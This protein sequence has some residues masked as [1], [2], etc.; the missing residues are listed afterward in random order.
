MEEAEGLAYDDLRSDS[1]AMVTGVDGSQG[2]ELSLHDVATHS[3][4]HTLRSSAPCMP[5]SPMEHMPLLEAAVAGIDAVKVHV[6][7]EKLNNL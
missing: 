2:P 1:D 3:P 7:E 6:D 4:P 5:G